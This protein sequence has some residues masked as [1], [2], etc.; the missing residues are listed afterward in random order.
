MVSDLLHHLDTHKST[1]PDRIH[2][3]VLREPVEVLPEPLS[4]IYQQ[5]RLTGEV[6]EDRSFDNV[7]PVHKRGRKEDPG[8]DRPVS[9]TWVPGKTMEQIV[10]SA[11]A[12][13]VQDSQGSG[14]V[15]RVYD[16]QVLLD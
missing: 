11:I 7:M 13:H 9:Q 4:I 12:R 16:G 5:S 3:S 10:L 2:P 6:P 15:T 8:N 1:G 14:P